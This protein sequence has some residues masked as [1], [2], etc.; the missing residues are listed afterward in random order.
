MVNKLRQYPGIRSISMSNGIPGFVNLHMGANMPGKNKSLSI[1]YADSSFMQTFGITVVNGRI[2]LP[3]DYGTTCLINESAYR[4]FGWTDLKEKRYD[5]GRKG[6]FEVIGVVNDFH[7]NSLRSAIEPMCILF[8]D[9]FYPTHVSIRV[10]TGQIREAV[11]YIRETWQETLPQ[12]PLQYE[13]YDSWFDAMYREEEKIG[14]AVGLFATLAIVVSC[15]GILGMAIYSVQKRTKEIGIRKVVG[16]TV[17]G[18]STMLLKDFTKWILLA[19]FIAWPIGWYAMNK[20]LQ[21]FAYRIDISW[22]MF[23][24]AG[25]LTLMIALLTVGW[26]AIR[27]ATAN[28]VEALRYE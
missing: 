6:G 15:M 23:A 28:P 10:A 24:L 25:G 7:F 20:W 14:T 9:D 4:Y 18:I 13:F 22:W 3:G 16:A 17:F 1:L 12:Y 8:P 21:D 2:P 26:Q 5:N 19:N 11:Q 27:A